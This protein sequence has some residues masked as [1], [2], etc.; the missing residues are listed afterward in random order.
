MKATLTDLLCD[1]NKKYY[2]ICTDHLYHEPREIL[3]FDTVAAN[4]VKIKTMLAAAQSDGTTDYQAATADFREALTLSKMVFE[5]KGF[6]GTS[7]LYV[8]S[9]FAFPF[10]I[11]HPLY[12]TALNCIDP[13]VCQEALDILTS[14]HWKEGAWDSLVMANIARDQLAARSVVFPSVSVPHEH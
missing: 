8:N 6:P 1:W 13:S 10:G 12:I 4:Y 11:I 5:A 3:A 7:L 9:P 2:R 14:R